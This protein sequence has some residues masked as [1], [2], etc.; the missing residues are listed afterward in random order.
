M[1]NIKKKKPRS[2]ESKVKRGAFA[3]TL[4]IIMIIVAWFAPTGNKNN[5]ENKSPNAVI[6]A[7]I[8]DKTDS[9]IKSLG[10]NDYEIYYRGELETIKENVILEEEIELNRIE[11]GIINIQNTNTNPIIKES[12]LTKAYKEKEQLTQRINKI[13]KSPNAIMKIYSQ[14]IKFKTPDG[15]KHSFHA[16]LLGKKYRAVFHTDL[17]NSQSLKHITDSL[18]NIKK[19]NT[20]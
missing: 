16:Q 3:L 14:H 19:S 12:Y 2:N 7:K 10:Y 13:K 15:H 9:L 17:E 8:E 6:L 1:L 4:V 20:L 11:T 5:S 18:S